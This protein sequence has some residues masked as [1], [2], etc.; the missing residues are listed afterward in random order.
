MSLVN[1]RTIN[2]DLLDPE[3]SANFD[4]TTLTPS[5][6]PV[7]FPDVQHI[8]T[9]VR[10]LLRG[11]DSEGALLG[12]LQTAPYGGDEKSKVSRHIIVGSWTAREGVE[13]LHMH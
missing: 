9:Q 4:L 12:A 6:A 2:V 13:R 1:W 10:Q 5:V 11:G 7:S 8:A 3:S